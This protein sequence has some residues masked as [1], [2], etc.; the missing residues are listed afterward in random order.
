MILDL[1][2]ND[3]DEKD[4]QNSQYFQKYCTSVLKI[5]MLQL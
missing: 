4:P 5:L 2:Q 1:R 3:A